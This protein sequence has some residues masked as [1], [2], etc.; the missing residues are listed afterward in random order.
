MKRAAILLLLLAGSCWYKPV[1]VDPPT[2][3]IAS[4]SRPAAQ[5]CREVGR[6]RC[7]SEQCKG[8]NM[9]YV[10]LACTGGK[11]VHRCVL[12]RSCDAD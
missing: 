8:A 11:Q 9:D 10:T 6:A 5:P 12:S 4:R 2:G 7:A 1:L 3:A